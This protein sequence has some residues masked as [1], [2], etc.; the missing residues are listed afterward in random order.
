[1]PHALN[2]DTLTH[3]TVEISKRGRT[4]LLRDDVPAKTMMR[5]FGLFSTQER[6]ETAI[7]AAQAA[8][9]DDMDAAMAEF[10]ASYDALEQ[11]AAAHVGAIFRHTD[12]D[13]T[14]EELRAVFSFEEMMQLV[15]LFFTLRSHRSSLPPGATSAPSTASTEPIPTSQQAKTNRAQRRAAKPA[16]GKHS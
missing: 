11:Q 7:K 1:M 6:I 13:I 8:H 2:F 10:Q 12:P 15:Q 3:D 5:A 9:P 16:S 4:W 14:D